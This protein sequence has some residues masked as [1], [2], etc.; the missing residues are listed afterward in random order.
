[1][2]PCS[3]PTHSTTPSSQ[4]STK[5]KKIGEN[6]GTG[7]YPLWLRILPLVAL[8]GIIG[9]AFALDL[10]SYLSLE[11][12]RNHRNGLT[13]W[14]ENA[15]FLASLV[16]VGVYIGVVLMSLPG[17]ILVTLA[18]GFLFGALQ[19]TFLTVIGA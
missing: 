7:S 17:P 15:G 10:D 12:L 14:V 2:N 18:G 8:I 4:H 16:Y 19:A 5:T 13:T 3:H 6:H 1:M 11:T 9:T